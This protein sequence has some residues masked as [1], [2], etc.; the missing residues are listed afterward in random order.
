MSYTKDEEELGYVRLGI[1]LPK[2]TLARLDTLK[3][4]AGLASRGRTIQ[5]L[6]DTIWEL[7]RDTKVI[8]DTLQKNPSIPSGEFVQAITP[9]LT[10]IIRRVWRFEKRE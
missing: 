6:I 3:D 5:E 2:D 10:D 1:L 8:M 7:Q 4:R 9:F